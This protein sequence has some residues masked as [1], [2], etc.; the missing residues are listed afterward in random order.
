MNRPDLDQTTCF[1]SDGGQFVT[2]MTLARLDR[3]RKV[4]W[5]P[6]TAVPEWIGTHISW[7]LAAVESGTKVMFSHSNFAPNVATVPTNAWTFY[8]NSLKAYVE[9]ETGQPGGFVVRG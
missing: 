2:S 6:D 1:R 8:L 3:P 9:T 5:I 4:E 7:E